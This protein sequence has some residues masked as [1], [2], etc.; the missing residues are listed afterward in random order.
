MNSPALKTAVWWAAALALVALGLCGFFSG[1]S[2]T[3]DDFVWL[4]LSKACPTPTDIFYRDALCGQF[5]RPL[6]QLW[7]VAVHSMAGASLVPYQVAFLALHLCNSVLVGCLAQKLA[8][9]QTGA[10]L[11]LFFSINGLFISPISNYY[12]YVFDLLGFC[13]YLLTLLLLFR[14]YRQESWL[15]GCASLVTAVAAYLSKEAFYTLP[16]AILLISGFSVAGESWKWPVLRRRQRWFWLHLATL[17]MAIG[18]RWMIIGNVGGYALASIATPSHLLAQVVDRA[19]IFTGFAG[20]SL[21]PHLARWNRESQWPL[22]GSIALLAAATLANRWQKSR[23]GAIWPWLWMLCAWA[24]SML[25]TTYAPV[26]W[27]ACSFGSILLLAVVLSWFKW[28][29]WIGLLVGVYYS[30]F[31]FLFYHERQP[32]I[33][34]LRMQEQALRELFPDGGWGRPQG[35]RIFLFRSCPDLFPDPIVKYGNIPGSPVADVLFFNGGNPIDWVITNP[36]PPISIWPIAISRDYQTGYVDMHEYRAY[37]LEFKERRPAVLR[38]GP[39]FRFMQWEPDGTL[40]DITDQNPWR[41]K[42]SAEP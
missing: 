35:E 41:K 1:T 4:Y 15:A 21:V 26:S 20:W 12:C 32:Y 40:T 29:R 6:G 18:W 27:Y 36:E 23:P 39:P 33:A 42:G 31:G 19:V 37:A 25:M 24:P 14:A 11:F 30:V 38:H 2:F 28:G 22:V 5:F 16:G 7:Y 10:L 8:G 13:F 3:Q 17:G 9:A 34:R